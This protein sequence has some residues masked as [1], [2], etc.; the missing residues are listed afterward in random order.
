MLANSPLKI[1]HRIVWYSLIAIF[2]FG[3]FIYGK[4]WTKLEG[5]ES[6]ALAMNKII[7]AYGDRLVIYNRNGD[8]IGEKPLSDLYITAPIYDMQ[9]YKNDLYLLNVRQAITR[10][11]IDNWK[12]DTAFNI[13]ERVWRYVI[14]SKRD[15]MYFSSVVPRSIRGFPRP[16]TQY[17]LRKYNILTEKLK[18]LISEDGESTDFNDL[19][20]SSENLLYVTNGIPEQ[21]IVFDTNNS[22]ILKKLHTNNKYI[23]NN[24]SEPERMVQ[25]KNGD[26]WLIVGN[27]WKP[28]SSII[29]LNKEWKELGRINIQG[30]DRPTDILPLRNS[31]IVS[32]RES[33][34]VYELD[35]NGNVLKEFQSLD[36][37]IAGAR[38]RRERDISKIIT[39]VSIIALFLLILYA[40]FRNGT[41]SEDA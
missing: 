3:L 31:Y 13:R 19:Y 41:N 14:D 24:Q 6:I 35:E 1:S 32:G 38:D 30:M 10:C 33:Y 39:I 34:K 28:G 29:R 40:I 37:T 12:C 17:K 16:N 25:G 26:W 5:P 8:I 21:V 15:V 23:I 9:I 7:V 27:R 18:T 4:A 22:E 2:C 11:N 20:V 36:S